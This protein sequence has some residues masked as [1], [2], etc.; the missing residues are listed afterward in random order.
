MNV[1]EN[2]NVFLPKTNIACSCNFYNMI[3]VHRIL[4]KITPFIHK[5]NVHT[6]AWPSKNDILGS[7]R[8]LLKLHGQIVSLLIK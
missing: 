6:Q 7:M 5:R 8:P 2:E 3:Y 4:K 1:K